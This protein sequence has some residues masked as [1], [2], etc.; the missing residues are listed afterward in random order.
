MMSPQKPLRTRMSKAFT[1][2]FIVMSLRK[3]LRTRMGGG[4]DEA[5]RGRLRRPRPAPESACTLLPARRKR[6]HSTQLRS[7]LYGYAIPLP[8]NNLPL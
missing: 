7:R 2:R 8:L 5:G 1:G 6:P 3:P 4:W